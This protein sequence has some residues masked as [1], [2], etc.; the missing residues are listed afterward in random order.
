M[1][2]FSSDPS[3][4]EQPQ[5]PPANDAPIAS[6]SDNLSPDEVLARHPAQERKRRTRSDKG[7]PR[8]PRSPAAEPVPTDVSG[9]VQTPSIAA[10]QITSA[11][12][13]LVSVVDSRVTA[14]IRR[15][16][17]KVTNDHTFAQEL[18]ESVALTQVETETIASLTVIVVN[19]YNILG[20][21]APEALLAVSLIGWGYRVHKAT[22]ELREL[23]KDIET[24]LAQRN[25]L[26]PQTEP[27]S[28]NRTERDG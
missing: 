18:A 2:L 24:T 13:S 19:K 9:G 12:K 10:E 4:V 28:D 20:T 25:G 16:A 17:V 7:I 23:R 5:A 27:A 11:I 8:G 26:S 21:Y 15:T 6:S 1:G 14:S 22:S 3:P